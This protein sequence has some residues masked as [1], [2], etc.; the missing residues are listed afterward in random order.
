MEDNADKKEKKE[1]SQIRIKIITE[2]KIVFDKTA[3]VFNLFKFYSFIS[4]I[5]DELH[6]NL[7]SRFFKTLNGEL[8]L[9]FN[10]VKDLIRNYYDLNINDY[11]SF[12]EFYQKIEQKNMVFNFL[13]IIYSEFSWR[14]LEEYIL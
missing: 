5:I 12:K 13:L 9:F 2:K 6:K 3:G 11:N 10:P 14:S 8:E 7:D 4:E 1:N